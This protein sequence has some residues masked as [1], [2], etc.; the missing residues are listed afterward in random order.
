[1]VSGAHKKGVWLGSGFED[2]DVRVRVQ[3]SANAHLRSPVKGFAD[4]PGLVFEGQQEQH[5]WQEVTG[6]L[7]VVSHPL[8]R[9]ITTHVFK[10]QPYKHRAAS[11]PTDAS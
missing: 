3:V 9:V 5:P 4:D 7:A 1:M 10:S 6:V 11:L 2:G 8:C